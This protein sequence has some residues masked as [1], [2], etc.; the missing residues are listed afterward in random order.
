MMY[1]S[2]KE[3]TLEDP[4]I[5][6][7]DYYSFDKLYNIELCN[8]SVIW[9]IYD[10]KKK[11]I[12]NKGLSRPCG[13]NHHRTSIH[14]EQKAIE[15]CRSRK[16]RNYEIII[17]RYSKSGE[18]KHKYCCTSCTKL[19]KKY[20]FT[21]RIFTFHNSMKCPAIIDNPP[22]SLCYQLKN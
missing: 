13:I 3:V 16:N 10:K 12:V 17:W 7:K 11:R 8:V 14:A 22:L 5:L 15:Y 4:P 9:I 18:I 20:N 19:A 6:I 2:K 1:L 21:N